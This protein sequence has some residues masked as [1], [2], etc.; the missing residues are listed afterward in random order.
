MIIGLLTNATAIAFHA[1]LVLTSVAV[2]VVE[3]PIADLSSSQQSNPQSVVLLP[4]LTRV[5]VLP[6]AVHVSAV[7]VVTQYKLRTRASGCVVVT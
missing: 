5:F 4:V 3:A 2:R 6:G 7:L 1:A